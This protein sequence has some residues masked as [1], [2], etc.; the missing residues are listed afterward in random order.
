MALRTFT[1]SGSASRR[2]IVSLPHSRIASEWKSGIKIHMIGFR[3]STRTFM[4]A[5]RATDIVWT[6]AATME[7]LI[8]PC[9]MRVHGMAVTKGI[10]YTTEWSFQRGT[11]TTIA[12]LTTVPRIQREPG[13][14]TVAIWLASAATPTMSGIRFIRLTLIILQWVSCISNRSHN[15]S[16]LC[17]LRMCRRLRSNATLDITGRL[18]CG[19]LQCQ[20]FSFSLTVTVQSCDFSCPHHWIQT[21]CDSQNETNS[22]RNIV[23]QKH[24]SRVRCN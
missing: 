15:K 1:T 2:S 7:T 6:W 8:T 22:S 11:K 21:L 3:S 23:Q 14:S 12:K 19:V 9:S 24:I 5:Q 10:S 13:G 20:C 17:I 18:Q 4:S 16:P